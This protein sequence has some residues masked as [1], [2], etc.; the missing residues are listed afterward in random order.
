[1]KDGTNVPP[2]Q[3]D[4]VETPVLSD[5]DGTNV[6]PAWFQG[7]VPDGTQSADEYTERQEIDPDDVPYGTPAEKSA[8]TTKTAAETQEP[9]AENAANKE[10]GEKAKAVAS[11]GEKKADDK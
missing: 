5:D 8:P 7:D 1:M 11:G 10:D 2:E 4:T 9:E 3:I 6:P